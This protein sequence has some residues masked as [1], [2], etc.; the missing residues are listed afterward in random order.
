MNLEKRARLR[1]LRVIVSEAIMVITVAI[2]VVVLALVVS[3][4]WLNSDFEVER[5]GMLQIYST[6]TGA[7][8]TVDG[9]TPWFQRTNTSKVLS[10]GGH[11]ISLTKDGYDSWSK[12]VT[13]SEGLLYRLHYPQLFL[14]NREKE[15]IYDATATTFVS[16]SPNRKLMLLVNGTTNWIL[17]N[18]DADNPK[19]TTIDI[20]EIF[21]SVSVANDA[22]AGLFTGEIS[23][24]EW[25]YANEHV[26]FSI[27]TN[28]G[29]EWVLLNVKRPTN[30]IN[31]TREF[32]T[33]FSSIKIFD[34]SA[35]NVLAVRNGNLHKINV[36]A[37]QVSAVLIEEIGNYDFYES[38]IVYIS[39]GQILLANLDNNNKVSILEEA[40]SDS[41]KVMLG[42][43]YENNYIFVVENDSLKVYQKEDFLE[44]F[45]AKLEFV[46]EEIKIGHHGMFVITNSGNHFATLDMES[47]SVREW[48]TDSAYFGW[49][50][51][52]MLYSV[53]GGELCVYDFDGLNRRAL[54]TN[55]SGRFPATITEN[56]WLYYFSDD[57]IIRERISE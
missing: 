9:D 6:P 37:R 4:Y 23:S 51:N 47:M 31:L 44:V 3:G 11:T 14:Q 5:Q 45:S 49:L 16:V 22:S 18:L 53:D 13:I 20:S 8:V 54:A 56:K 55:V 25:D 50:S 41:T 2:T 15:T 42:K 52:Y 21:S 32:A 26:L 39:H 28:S 33:N 27:K 43:F 7:N 57:M 12:T 10:S 24:A 19:P 17:L 35:N 1:S 36:G 30:S 29:T 38:E 46:P 40:V 48:T 34:N